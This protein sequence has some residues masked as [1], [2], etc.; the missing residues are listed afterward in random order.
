MS[1]FWRLVCAGDIEAALAMLSAAEE[2][3]DVVVVDDCELGREVQP[4]AVFVPRPHIAVPGPAQ[5]RR[6]LSSWETFDRAY[7]EVDDADCL[8]RAGKLLEELNIPGFPEG[9]VLRSGDGTLVVPPTVPERA[10]WAPLFAQ[11]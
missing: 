5:L 7:E 3:W 1:V 9:V 2:R 8:E 11:R 10:L 4:G 6:L